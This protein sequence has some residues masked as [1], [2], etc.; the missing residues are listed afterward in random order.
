MLPLLDSSLSENDDMLLADRYM[1]NYQL[2]PLVFAARSYVSILL[3]RVNDHPYHNIDHTFGVYLRTKYLCECEGITWDE[4]EDMLIAA[5]FHDTGFI[6]IYKKNEPKGAQ[7][8]R[9]WLQKKHHNEDRIKRV[10]RIIMATTFPDSAEWLFHRPTDIFEEII[11]DADMDNLGC[12]NSFTL[13]AA[14]Y[15]EIRVFGHST[16]SF[17]EYL[18]MDREIFTQFHFHTRTAKSER[19]FQKNQN[20]NMLEEVILREEEIKTVTMRETILHSLQ[21]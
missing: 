5:L 3:E 13:S 18:K 21:V 19:N 20:L 1:K 2:S 14:I 12:K 11:Q 4:K 10:E 9:S 8:A 17:F 6:E 16:L 7:I 15:D